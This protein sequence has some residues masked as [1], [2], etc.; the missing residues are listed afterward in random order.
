MKKLI[1]IFL[2]LL[3]LIFN[4][5]LTMNTHFCGGFAIETSVS[6]GISNLDCGMP[7]MDQKCKTD[8]TD[9]N[10]VTQKPCCENQHQLFQFNE[11]ADVRSIPVDLNPTFF[12]AFIHAFVQPAISLQKADIKYTVYFPPP[13]NQDIPVLFQSFLI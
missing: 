6:L 11:N 4:I 9:E 2:V 8:V 5:G 3:L 12:I 1:S 10:Q 7:A 13:R